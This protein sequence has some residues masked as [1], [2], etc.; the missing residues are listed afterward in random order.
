MLI[1]DQNKK[2]SKFFYSVLYHNEILNSQ[3]N[4]ITQLSL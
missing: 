3:K 4:H 2:W 1:L